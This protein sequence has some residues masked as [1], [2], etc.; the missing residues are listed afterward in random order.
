M[1][2]SHNNVEPESA[3][4]QRSRDPKS[5]IPLWIWVGVAAVL[6]F[7]VYNA[8]EA[9]SLQNRIHKMQDSLAAQ[10]KLQEESAQQFVRARREAVILTDPKSLKIKM[11]AAKKGLP[12]LQATWHP[13]LGIVLSGQGLPAPSRSGTLQLWLIPKAPR[14]KS[15]S[16]LTLR[17]D[18]NGELDLL[19]ANPPL[20]PSETKA[21]AIT[22]EPSGGSVQPSGTPMWAGTVPGK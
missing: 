14:A 9:R 16:S 2:T 13:E 22:E 3:K 4:R 17:P 19:V 7:A 8:H 6:L 11:S 21:L 20:S 12:E 1:G 10:I 5:A 15:S 18:P